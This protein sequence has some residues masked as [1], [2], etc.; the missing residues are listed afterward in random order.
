VPRAIVNRDTRGLVN[1]VVEAA[2]G[3]VRGVYAVAD[4]AGEMITAGVYAIRSGM[5]ARASRAAKRSS[6][7]A[8]ERCTRRDRAGVIASPAARQLGR[9]R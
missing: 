6:S 9:C 3:R 4:G 1:L 2:T 7:S 5:T 8:K